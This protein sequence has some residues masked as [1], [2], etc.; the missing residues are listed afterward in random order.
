MIKRQFTKVPKPMSNPAAGALQ[1]TLKH[2][3]LSNAEAA[4]AM[5]IPRSRLS[6]IF[7]GRKGVS[8]DT[9]LRFEQYLSISAELILRL[10]AK[11]DFY[12]A[13]HDK[14]KEIQKEVKKLA[15]V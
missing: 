12:K 6:D 8:A 3:G 10:Q 4:R 7:S 14:N 1:D 11:Y 2:Y 13:Y 15:S 9:A 5:N